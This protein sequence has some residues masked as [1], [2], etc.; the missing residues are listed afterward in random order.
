MS[1][2]MTIQPEQNRASLPDNPLVSVIIPSYNSRQWVGQAIDSILNQTYPNTEI[3]VIDDGSTDDTATF[4]AQEYKDKIKYVYQPNSEVSAAR[5]H[6]LR[7]AT[8]HLISFLDADDWIF[9]EKIQRQV[10]YLRDHPEKDVVYCDFW[11]AYDSD[12]SNLLNS[13][14][15]GLVYRKGPILF[16]LLSL[17]TTVPH[18]MLLRKEC[19]EKAGN[20]SEK[21]HYYEDWELWVRIA[22]NGF[23]FGY[24]DEKLV[25]YRLHASS[26]R[27]NLYKMRINRFRAFASVQE[28]VPPERLESVLKATGNA[29]TF[30]FGLARALFE[31]GFYKNGYR[32]AFSSMR[33]VHSRRAAF[34]IFCLGYLLLLPFTG[35]TRLE[36]LISKFEQLAARLRH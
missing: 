30:K 23:E 6:G 8:G 10:T 11:A 20:F 3:I 27:N 33:A 22:G 25:V 14:Q 36:T 9:P 12:P 7:L 13:E 34:T 21:L 32:Q 28:N 5:N 1:L 35:Y 24:L 15:C 29:A 2:E 26:K 17:G 16:R 4:L 18:S 31:Q 19:F